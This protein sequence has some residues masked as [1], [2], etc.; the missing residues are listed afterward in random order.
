MA[1]TARTWFG[2]GPA[3]P[4]TP[5][6]ANTDDMRKLIWM[7]YVLPCRHDAP[8][9]LGAPQSHGAAARRPRLPHRQPALPG[10]VR[11]VS[12]EGTCGAA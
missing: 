1:A 9:A 2:A 10:L 5:N 4:N 7:S 11:S 6:T 3:A 12:N 8:Q